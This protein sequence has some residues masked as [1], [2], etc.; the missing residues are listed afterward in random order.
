M[1]YDYATMTAEGPPSDIIEAR[2]EQEIAA[3]ARLL[4][5]FKAWCCERYAHRSW[6][7]E[8]YLEDNAWEAELASLGERYSPPDGA[9]FLARRGMRSAGCASIRRHGPSAEIKYLYVRPLVRER[10][11]GRRLVD[12]AVAWA[13]PRGCRVLRLETGDLHHEALGF[14]RALGFREVAPYRDVPPDL[15]AHLVFLEKTL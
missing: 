5:E 10:G 12:A 7:I 2:T 8:S 1:L 15:A 9:L 4:R 14:C 11:L 3:V 6:Q 13:K